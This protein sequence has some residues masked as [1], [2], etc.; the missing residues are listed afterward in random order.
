MLISKIGGPGAIY[1]QAGQTVTNV[2]TDEE[3]LEVN[4]IA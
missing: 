4:S 3:A 2:Q 1:E